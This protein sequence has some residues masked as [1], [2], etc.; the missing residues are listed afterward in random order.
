MKHE[1]LAIRHVYFEDL[2]S[3]EL[4]LGDRGLPVR[5]LDV[6]RGGGGG[7]RPRAPPPPPPPP[8]RRRA[9]VDPHKT[10]LPPRHKLIA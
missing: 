3:L 1:V 6:G 2:G 9:V 7:G 8:R 5:Y 4:V 10:H